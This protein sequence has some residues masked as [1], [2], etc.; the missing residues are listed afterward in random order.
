MALGRVRSDDDPRGPSITT[1]SGA[2]F[3]IN[4][5]NVSEI[6][7][8]DIAH[9]LA[10]NCRFN[11]HVSRFYSVAEHCVRATH[12]VRDPR[13]ELWALLHDVSEAFIPDIAG[14][15]KHVMWG[16]DLY[17][18]RLLGKVAQQYLLTWPMPD[19]VVL[20]DQ[21]MTALEAAILFPD[22]PD[23]VYEYQISKVFLP[24]TIGWNPDR[25]QEEFMS[26]YAELTGAGV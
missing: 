25:A 3:Y 20:I 1:L 12:Q 21:Q 22:P 18:Q 7:I 15:F 2:K 8:E 4:E 6:P 11:G 26:K 24:R 19:E 9:A 17:E 13:N 14:P 23:W 16:F 5:C 10:F